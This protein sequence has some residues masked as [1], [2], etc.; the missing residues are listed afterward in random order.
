MPP[1]I[2]SFDSPGLGQRQRYSVR[3][4]KG[5]QRFDLFSTDGPP[6]YAVPTNVGPRTMDYVA[7]FNQGIYNLP[8]GIKVFAGTTDDAFWIDLGGTFDTVNLR[9][10]VAPGVL[11]AA[12]DAADQNF[13]ANTVSGYA[14]NTLAIEVPVNLLTRTG[15]VEPATSPAATI[16]VWGT[17]SRPRVSVR[18]NIH[19]I[20][21]RSGQF[22]QVQRMGNAFINELIIGTGSKDRFSMDEPANDSQFASFFTDPALPRVLN[23]LTGGVLAIPAPPRVDLRPL[24]RYV[25]PIAA[26]G[27]PM[28]PLADML[29][30]NTGVAPTPYDSASRLGLLAGDKAGYPNGRRVFDDVTDISLRV[31]G[32]GV[33]A[34]P[35]RGF[36]PALVFEPLIEGFPKLRLW[37]AARIV[38]GLHTTKVRGE[39]GTIEAELEFPWQRHPEFIANGLIVFLLIVTTRRE[40]PRRGVA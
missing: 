21:N 26:A 36:N 13:A 15:R 29:R 4:F 9:S 32:G 33:L 14:V 10:S 39:F 23:A 7:L 37:Q 8:S 24:V 38:A 11:S 31:V 5:N 1:Q 22:R 3:A 34:A 20:P 18:R 17:T 19:G 27:T 30:L 35:F 40:R 25:L 12:Q 28:G 6:L 16:G 2:T